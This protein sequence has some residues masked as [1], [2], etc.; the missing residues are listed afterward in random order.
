VDRFALIAGITGAALLAI[1]FLTLISLIVRIVRRKLVFRRFVS[2][3][4]FIII[5]TGFS[6]A[7]IYLSLFVQTFS[8]YTHEERIGTIFAEETTAGMQVYFVDERTSTEYNFQL[9]GD[10][11]MV[12]GCI[13]R[14]STMLRWLGAGTYYKVTRFRGRWERPDGRETTEFEIQPQGKLWRFLLKNSGSLPF[15]DTAFGI[16]AYQY[17]G[18]KTYELSI[19]ETGFIV[20]KS[21]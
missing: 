21:K 7:C 20:R 17:P 14:W 18:E 10:Q 6:L 11:W 19:N 3:F 8:R 12:E 5:L 13:L 4:L 16:G 1:A 2:S 9:I 15:V